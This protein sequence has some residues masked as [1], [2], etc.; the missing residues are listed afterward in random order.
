MSAS[1]A[2]TLAF[3]GLGLLAGTAGAMRI[4]TVPVGNP[5]NAA[6]M[7]YNLIIKPD[8]FGRVDYSYR[9]GK[10]EVT[11]GQYCDFLNAV[12]KTDT[13]GLYNPAMDTAVSSYGCNI[14][15][16]GVSGNYSYMVAD[17]WANRPVNNV[18]WG[19]A[20][21]YVN[22]LANGRRIGAQD[23]TTT[24]DGSYYLNGARTSAQLQAVTRK[25]NATFVIPTEDEWYKAAYHKN[26]GITGNYWD[27]PTRGNAVPSNDLLHP[28]P[29]NNANFYDYLDYTLGGPYWRTEVG[30]LGNSPS[31]Y[32]T[33]DQ[34]GNVCEWTETL[35]LG[36]ARGVR[37]GSFLT[38][39]GPLRGQEWK[40][41]D[42]ANENDSFGFRIARVPE[43]VTLGLLALGV[44]VMFGHKRTRAIL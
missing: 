38:G 12:A 35:L 1:K 6:D 33:F 8:G 15:R 32:G 34:G 37:G 29:G 18:S 30:A 7:R 24:E 16:S 42:P 43:P 20:A 25:Q 40:Y 4:E 3:C 13:Y 31:P 36:W 39:S 23:A 26:D 5:G 21:R 11:A 19:D 14:K 17:E 41:S 22:W 10:Y 44:Q 28:D 9:I 2:R 27:Y